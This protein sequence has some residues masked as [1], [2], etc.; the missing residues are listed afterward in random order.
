MK[1]LTLTLRRN[2]AHYNAPYVNWIN[3]LRR[4]R[5]SVRCLNKAK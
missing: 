1:N 4:L 3:G 5:K 2:A